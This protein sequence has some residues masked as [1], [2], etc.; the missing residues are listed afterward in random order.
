VLIVD[1]EPLALELAQ[2]TF[3]DAGSKQRRRS[4]ASN[5]SISFARVLL[6][7]SWSCS[8]FRC[9]SWMARRPSRACARC[10][11]TSP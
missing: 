11:R 3:E 6:T 2:T 1:D 8:T 4:P 9:P 10:R 5:V 7:S